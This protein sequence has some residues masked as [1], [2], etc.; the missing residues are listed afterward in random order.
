VTA[1][2]RNTALTTLKV[3]QQGME[4]TQMTYCRSTVRYVC[5]SLLM[6]SA[7]GCASFSARPA[8]VFPTNEIIESATAYNYEVARKDKDLS[9]N[10]PARNKFIA[11]Q[12]AA[13]DARYW[14]FLTQLSRQNRGTNFGL[15]L[16]GLGLTGGAT[17]AGEATANAL[18]AGAVAIAGARSAFSKD[19]FFELTLF[20][21]IDEMDA[22]RSRAR[23]PL[24]IGLTKGV[25]E[26]PLELAVIDLSTYEKAASID[27]A[28]QRI[29]KSAADNAEM[30][31]QKFTAEVRGCLPD[32]DTFTARSVVT[33]KIRALAADPSKIEVL[34]KMAAAFAITLNKTDGTDKPS[35]DLEHEIL[36]DV[37]KK[38]CSQAQLAPILAELNASN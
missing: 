34:K 20:A 38:Y 15:N 18:S 14:K 12:M 2:T 16:L 8:T 29:A 37:S 26:Y 6:A 31:D 30:A 25:E 11:L 32:A 3:W 1:I 5:L 17:I 35:S 22:A 7:S 36:I 21:A 9:A 13:I 10:Q 4:I 27:T 19:L 33:R 24:V 28:I 23:A